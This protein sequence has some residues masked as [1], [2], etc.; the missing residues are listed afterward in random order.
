[1]AKIDRLGWAAGFCVNAYGVRVGVRTNDP[2]VLPDLKARLPVGCEAGESR[3]VDALYS[4]VAGGAGARPGLRRYHLL[5]FGAERVVRE[6]ELE[7]VLR[8]FADHV[9]IHVAEFAPQRV[10]VHAGVVGWKG[11]AILLPG[12]SMSGKSTLVA[13]LVKA[14][15][16]YYSDEFAVLDRRGQVHP[17]TRP[18]SLRQGHHRGPLRVPAEELGKVG[19]APLP[20]RWIVVSRYQ[21]GARWR[22]R[23]VSPGLAVLDLL[24]NA[25]PARRDP[26]AVLATLVRAAAQA[27]AVRGTRGEASELVDILLQ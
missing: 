5:Y 27:S 10:F 21:R 1:M 8:G 24:D 26:N 16:E 7:P 15:A 3:L 4:V 14:G 19:V 17:F 13:E 2:Q 11:Q 9:E 18:L 12:R 23:R 22:P 6:L 25:V 20:V